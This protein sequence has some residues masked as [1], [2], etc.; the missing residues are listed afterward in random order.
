MERLLYKAKNQLKKSQKMRRG[1]LRH[2]GKYLQG[3]ATFPRQ[4]RMHIQRFGLHRDEAYF[5][6]ERRKAQHLE[7]YFERQYTR[8][9]PTTKRGPLLLESLP[10]S[11]TK[12]RIGGIEH[13]DSSEVQ[14]GPCSLCGAISSHYDLC[15]AS[16]SQ[17]PISMDGLDPVIEKLRLEDQKMTHILNI[18]QKDP[19]FLNF[20]YLSK[21][22]TTMEMDELRRTNDSFASPNGAKNLEVVD[23]SDSESLNST[24]RTSASIADLANELTMAAPDDET[25]TAFHPSDVDLNT[26]PVMDTSRALLIYDGSMDTMEDMLQGFKD[27]CTNRI[28]PQLES[29]VSSRTKALLVENADFLARAAEFVAARRVQI[30]AFRLIQDITACAAEEFESV[31][32]SCDKLKEEIEAVLAFSISS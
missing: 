12:N 14:S 17:D 22:R 4:M 28:L 20:I 8:V 24:P 1:E 27:L 11:Y 10:K 6:T 21:F 23:T 2:Y 16:K 7:S 13:R 3:G 29:A 5:E 25:L 26:F 32:S 30:C 9:A 15:S 18:K 31:I 19:R